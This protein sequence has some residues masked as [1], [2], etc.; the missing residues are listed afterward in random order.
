MEDLMDRMMDGWVVLE[1]STIIIHLKSM[2]ITVNALLQSYTYTFE[3][4]LQNYIQSRKT[5]YE[6]L[7]THYKLKQRP[8]DMKRND[9]P[10]IN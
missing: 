2:L 5:C 3:K 8:P 7:L 9:L 10:K 6:K 4:R 1:L